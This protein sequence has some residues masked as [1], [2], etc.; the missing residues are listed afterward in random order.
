MELPV[1]SK[2]PA[3]KHNSQHYTVRIAGDPF[4]HMISCYQHYNSPSENIGSNHKLRHNTHEVLLK[5]YG[6]GPTYFPLKCRVKLGELTSKFYIYG[7]K[8]AQE[9][10]PNK[11][12][13]C[14]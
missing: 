5:S 11:A 12:S 1:S 9:Q 8:Q 10:E 2:F 6:Q 13:A 7:N 3:K 14:N 4:T